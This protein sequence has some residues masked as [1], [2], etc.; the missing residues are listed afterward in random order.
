MSYIQFRQSCSDCG[1]EWNAAFGI[2]GTTIIAQPP[3]KCPKCGLKNINKIEDGWEWDKSGE[4][5]KITKQD[6]F[7]ADMRDAG[8]DPENY[9]GKNFYRGLA[10]TVDRGKLQDVIRATKLELQ[11]DSLGKNDLV[12]YPAGGG[13]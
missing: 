9:V 2:V 12:I 1:E 5:M 7:R 10:V 6:V 3:E 13:S 11:W 8:F 4:G